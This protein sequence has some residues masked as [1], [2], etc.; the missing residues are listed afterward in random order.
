MHGLTN[1]KPNGARRTDALGLDTHEQGRIMMRSGMLS[2]TL[3]PLVML[4]GGGCGVTNAG[5]SG[6]DA[7][8]SN[9]EETDAGV[10]QPDSATTPSDDD[11]PEAG[12]EQSEPPPPPPDD[13]GH[14][15]G[16]GQTSEGSIERCP[17]EY[18]Q[19]I[20]PLSG[21]VLS[22]YSAILEIEVEEVLPVPVRRRG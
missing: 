5:Q 8:A 13:E 10:A 18:L 9:A 22:W 12:V 16:V 17:C 4:I 21:T 6:G 14:D 3:L 20:P 19:G 15:D 2:A 7:G 1:P 11:A